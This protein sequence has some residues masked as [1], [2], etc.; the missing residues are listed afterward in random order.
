[1]SAPDSTDRLIAEVEE[2]V[3]QHRAELAAGHEADLT[4][5]V[6]AL[7]GSMSD[8]LMLA[9]NQRGVLPEDR[10]AD[11]LLSAAHSCLETAQI[12]HREVQR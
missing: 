1:M 7:Y 12:L 9:G 4:E 5:A 6:R 8:V 10:R 2:I 11:L 3:E